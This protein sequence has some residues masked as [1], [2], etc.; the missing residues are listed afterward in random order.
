MLR[1]DFPLEPS[2]AE[3]RRLVDAAMNRI[4]QHI[5]SLP[6]QPSFDVDG[7]E[8]V[9][10]Q[11]RESLPEHG[12][13][14][15]SLLDL[16]FDTAAPKSFNAAGPGYLAYIPGGGLFH[17]AV[18]DLI[19][20]SLN[21]Y[22]GVWL[23]APGLSQLE[24]NVIAWFAEI[25]GYPPSA[26]GILTSGGS[27][28][29]FSAFVV[30]R[31][32]R[33]GSDFRQGTIY[34]S[35]QA[36]HS[37]ARAAMLAGFPEQAVRVI[38]SDG[39]FRVRVDAIRDAIAVDRRD[40]LRP[41]LVVGNAGT[42]NTGA[43][44][45]LTALADLAVEERL[46]FH[47]DAAYGGF[48]MLTER[49]R[50][51]M[52]GLDRADSMT[53]DPHKG[54]FL[55]YGTGSLMVRD[56]QALRRAHR[57]DAE[58]LP[59]MREDEAFVDFCQYSPELSRP[60]RGLRIWLPFRLFGAGVFREQLDEKLDLTLWA[61]EQLRGIDGMEIVAEPELSLVAFRLTRPGLGRD[62]L[63]ALNGKLL[64]RING[65]RRVYLTATTI[66]GDFLLRICVVS[67]R[68]H[69]ERMEQGMEDIKAAVS[70]VL[71]S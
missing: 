68:T 43:V 70:E 51:A 34:T 26:K 6:D 2:A 67:F 29:N 17:S 18:A 20:E 52:L 53:L 32:E 39:R 56:G 10:N 24:A 62:E 22:V 7:A 65:R 28:A 9:A 8:E 44:D 37:V 33:L 42:T 40:G 31:R 36:H 50:A 11:L 58:Y 38:E 69:M 4:V 41:F 57:L 13:P 30:A 21:R 66:R 1:S 46:W 14:L 63:N 35:D 15:E 49:G 5:G 55:P 71:Q 25:V 60:F 47:A 19:A 45:D 59:E 54:L 61:T 16:V 48:F 12:T 64:D 23:A 3:M 27:L